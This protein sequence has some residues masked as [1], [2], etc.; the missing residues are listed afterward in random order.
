MIT[1][2]QAFYNLPVRNLDRAMEFFSQIGFEFLPQYTSDLAAAMIIHDNTFV[3][4]VTEDFF[5]SG[6]PGKQIVN[7]TNNVESIIA[8]ALP[9]RAEVDRRTELAIAAGATPVSPPSDSGFIY[10][11]NIQ[12]LDGHVWVF[13]HLDFANASDADH[14]GD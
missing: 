4:L 8:L 10:S 7:D 9:S 5:Q 14:E 3:M 2:Q 1:V 12:D 13:N 6:L 11:R